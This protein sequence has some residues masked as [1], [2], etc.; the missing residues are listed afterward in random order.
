MLDAGAS[1]NPDGP[2]VGGLGFQLYSYTELAVSHPIG[3]QAAQRRDSP[4]KVR[5]ARCQRM[6]VASEGFFYHLILCDFKTDRQLDET[7]LEK[8]GNIVGGW[9]RRFSQE[10]KVLVSPITE[11]VPLYRTILLM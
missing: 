1:Y 6:S 5:V 3:M 7:G 2:A 11:T 8:I 10:T 9:W 4:G